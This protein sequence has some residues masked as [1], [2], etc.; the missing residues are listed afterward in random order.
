MYSLKRF[1]S[2]YF[3]ASMA[4]VFTLVLSG[5]GKKNDQTVPAATNYVAPAAIATAT[6]NG[7]DLAASSGAAEPDASVNG[8]AMGQSMM[9]RHHRQAMDHDAMRAGSANQNAPAPD[10]TPTSSAMPMKDM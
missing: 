6:T 7:S 2:P 10:S 1:L 3:G 5:C 8:P 9:E 4:I